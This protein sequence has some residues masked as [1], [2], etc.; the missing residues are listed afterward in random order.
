MPTLRITLFGKG[1]DVLD[2]VDVPVTGEEKYGPG[3]ATAAAKQHFWENHFSADLDPLLA[4]R[5]N[6]LERLSEVAGELERVQKAARMFLEAYKQ[7][8]QAAVHMGEIRGS[9]ITLD[10]ILAKVLNINLAMANAAVQEAT[11][12]N[13]LSL[14]KKFKEEL[15]ARFRRKKDE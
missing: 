10:E 12:M 9:F 3:Q 5:Q 8:P 13:D 14:P 4:T 11:M 6:M 2:T 15:Q 7:Q 1:F